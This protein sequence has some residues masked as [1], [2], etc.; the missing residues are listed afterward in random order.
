VTNEPRPI[1]DKTMAGRG[2]KPANPGVPQY[3]PKRW[4]DA[5]FE[6][7]DNAESEPCEPA[8]PVGF[9][10]KDSGTRVDFP[11]GSR[12]DDA[13]GKGRFDL[14]PF[15]AVNRYAQLLERGADKYEARNW[16]KGQ[17]FSRVFSSMLRHAHQAAAGQTDE[18][19][20]AAVIFNAAALITFAER[21]ARG[22]L[23]DE[24]NDMPWAA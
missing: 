7:V 18:D 2:P 15:E 12:R 11:T 9:T 3:G 4:I 10:T 14:L 23:P 8:E 1:S 6:R 5:A 21:I 16:E 17:P 24:L 22:E 19:H 20:L 13:T